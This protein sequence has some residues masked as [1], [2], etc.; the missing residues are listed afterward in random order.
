MGRINLSRVILGGILAGIVINASEFIL[1]EKVMKTQWEEAMKALGKT[2]PQSGGAM[3]VWMIWGF[4]AG[5][6]AVWLYAAIRPRYGAGPA[7]AA[8]AGLAIWFLSCALAAVAMQ[9][10]GLFPLSGLMLVWVLVESVVAT[11]AG[12]SIYRE[13]SA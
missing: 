3:V 6:A 5:I 7:T 2:M 12:A 1:N 13:G 9:N 10:M 8:R 11:I 4:A